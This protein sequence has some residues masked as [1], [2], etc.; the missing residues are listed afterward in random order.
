MNKNLY[1]IATL[2]AAKNFPW[3]RTKIKEFIKSG[4]LKATRIAG[5]YWLI[6]KEDVDEF[7]KE[8]KTPSRQNP[9]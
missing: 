4:K 6:H 3:K 1:T 8:N 9:H 7:L 2:S 5:T